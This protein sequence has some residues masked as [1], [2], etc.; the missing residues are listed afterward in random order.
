MEAVEPEVNSCDAFG[1]DPAPS[2][3]PIT[4]LGSTVSAGRWV[5]RTRGRP[6]ARWPAPWRATTL[7]KGH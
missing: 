6:R 5:M 1:P 2:N 4:F 3:H 7:R